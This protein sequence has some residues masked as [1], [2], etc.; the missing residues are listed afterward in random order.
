MR[1]GTSIVR[2]TT[3]RHKVTR[4]QLQGYGLGGMRG[5]GLER[6]RGYGLEA[7]GGTEG[8]QRGWCIRRGCKGGNRGGQA[9]GGTEREYR[10]QYRGVRRAG[11]G[12]Y[13]GVER[14]G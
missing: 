11:G 8:A 6:I 4:G 10:D 1:G 5:T 14:G 7:I 2:L 9:R 3:N 12:R 13:R